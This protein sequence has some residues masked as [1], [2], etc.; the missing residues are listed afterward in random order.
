[1]CNRERARARALC[2]CLFLCA[3]HERSG[4]R[5]TKRLRVCRVAFPL[6]QAS[7]DA[8]VRVDTVGGAWVG[9]EMAG[10]KAGCPTFG[11]NPR[12]SLR[13]ECEERDRGRTIP[14]FISMC[15]AGLDPPPFPLRRLA[16]C[17][18]AGG[19]PEGPAPLQLG[20]QLG[21]QTRIGV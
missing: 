20:H 4:T 16:V 15:L 6:L 9:G 2:L 1:M 19:S 11:F 17:G 14:A 12:F 8:H 5:L 18:W 21:L 13:L 10:G 7:E 3:A